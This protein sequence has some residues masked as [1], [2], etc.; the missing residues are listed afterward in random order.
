MKRYDQYPDG[1]GREPHATIMDYHERENDIETDGFEEI[2]DACN[3]MNGKVNET[4]NSISCEMGSAIGRGDKITF[5]R[6]KN[7]LKFRTKHIRGKI[8]NVIGPERLGRSIISM[9]LKDRKSQI[10]FGDLDFE[11]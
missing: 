2:R 5:N 1:M 7:I 8:H 10:D 11:R 3:R 6:K 9:V 4:E